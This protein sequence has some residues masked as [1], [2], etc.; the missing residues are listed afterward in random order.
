LQYQLES[1][2]KEGPK[3]HIFDLLLQTF[4]FFALPHLFLT[5]VLKKKGKKRA[6]A[7]KITPIL[8]SPAT[9]GFKGETG[10]RRNLVIF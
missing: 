8:G 3:K 2:F 5:H 6:H 4:F 10:G 7:V 1:P 9:S